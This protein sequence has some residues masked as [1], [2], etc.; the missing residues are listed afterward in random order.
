MGV[1]PRVPV[2]PAPAGAGA[3]C[4]TVSLPHPPRFVNYFWHRVFD[5]PF[6]TPTQ[7]L[8]EYWC[9]SCLPPSHRCRSALSPVG[10][11][12][13]RPSPHKRKTE[14]NRK[15]LL[16]SAGDRWSPLQDSYSVAPRSHEPRSTENS[17]KQMR[18]KRNKRFPVGATIGRPSTPRKRTTEAN[19][20]F[21]LRNAGDRWSPL[22]KTRFPSLL[23]RQLLS[24]FCCRGESGAMEKHRKRGSSTYWVRQ[25][26]FSALAGVS[27]RPRLR[28]KTKIPL[29]II[30]NRGNYFVPPFFMYTR[31]LRVPLLPRRSR[32]P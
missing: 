2:S 26:P 17:A 15:F 21:L 3:L 32:E 8:R 9:A 14:T 27:R 19:R 28:C 4:R 29:S 30:K 6:F 22:Q 12:T 5:V 10:A 18:G 31:V 23:L 20:K 16:Q 1:V 24:H 25:R 11:T 7:P 13:G